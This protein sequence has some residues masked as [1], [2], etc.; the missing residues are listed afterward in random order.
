MRKSHKPFRLIVNRNTKEVFYSVDDKPFEK[1]S[2]KNAFDEAAKLT[3]V[4]RSV[5]EPAKILME[6]AGIHKKENNE[7]N[8]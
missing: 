4:L 2:S 7:D 8:I 1:D 5:P 3:M 6:L